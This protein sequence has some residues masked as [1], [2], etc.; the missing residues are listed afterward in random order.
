MELDGQSIMGGDG[1]PRLVVVTG[2]GVCMC[3]NRKFDEKMVKIV[4]N[5][6]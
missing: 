2:S 5:R 1:S 3:E 6:V 4:Q